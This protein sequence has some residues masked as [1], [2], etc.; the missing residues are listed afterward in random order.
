MC[1]QPWLAIAS[2]CPVCRCAVGAGEEEKSGEG[3]ARGGS[4]AGGMDTARSTPE[5]EPAELTSEAKKILASPVKKSSVVPLT[6]L[7]P[8]TAGDIAVAAAV[9]AAAAACA[10]GVP[11][12]D[13]MSVATALSQSAML[14]SS[15]SCLSLHTC[16]EEADDERCATCGDGDGDGDDK[17]VKVAWEVMHDVLRAVESG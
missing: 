5:A 16:V 4:V 17:Y 7:S 3:V 9:A 14:A 13:A 12:E 2:S 10:A 11:A 6:L 15:S 1:V 8:E